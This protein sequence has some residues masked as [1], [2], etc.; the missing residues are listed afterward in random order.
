MT[1]LPDKIYCASVPHST[2]KE[3]AQ[4]ALRAGRPERGIFIEGRGAENFTAC[5][6]AIRGPGTLGLV[7]GY[8]VLGDGR[9]AIMEKLRVLRDRDI[10]PYNFITGV[11]DSAELLSEAIG[12]ISG[13]R[14][15]RATK[16]YPR[17][18]GRR[19]GQMKGAR[20]DEYRTSIMP[21]E[22]LQRLCQHS[23][24]TWQ[25]CADILGGKPFSASTLRRRYGN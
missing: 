10:T 6:A 11:V 25:D 13:A 19:G 18:L 17:A 9:S 24:L 7:G 20:A 2:G 3:Q 4:I 8:R 22:I 5:V 15:L 12:K 1:A 23:K 21:D 16:Q 14:A